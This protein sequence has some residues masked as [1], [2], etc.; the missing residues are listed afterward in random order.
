MICQD[1]GMLTPELGHIQGFLVQTRHDIH[2]LD[3]QY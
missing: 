3:H 1:H 2:I